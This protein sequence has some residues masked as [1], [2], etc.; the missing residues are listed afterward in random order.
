MQLTKYPQSCFL[1][2][3]KNKTILI[4]PGKYTLKNNFKISSLPKIDIIL[5]THSHSDHLYI[6]IIK[7]ILKKF[8]SNIFTNE[9]CYKIL[10]K[11]KIKSKIIKPN[12][13]KTIDN[14]QIKGIKQKHGTPMGVTNKM[15]DVIGFLIDNIFYHPGD[16]ILVDNK[17][18]T[19]IIA[20]PISGSVTMNPEEAIQF[21]KK[22]KP[23]LIIPM[24]YEPH[25][26]HPINDTKLFN[27]LI[28]KTKLNYK[29]LKDGETIEIN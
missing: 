22:I 21:A 14:M 12:E 10:K 11:N 8:N 7:K 2:K 19:Q 1:I 25:P 5:I 18:Q 24:H 6:D 28:K 20:I 17:L 15:P 13:I 27:K 23:N 4:D 16:S 29:I 3:Y 26:L 9:E